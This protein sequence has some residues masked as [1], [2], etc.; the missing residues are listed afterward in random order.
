MD[1]FMEDIDEKEQLKGDRKLPTGEFIRRIAQY[2]RPELP[3][4]LGAALLLLLNVVFDIVL[5]L[6]TS[7]MTDNLWGWQAV[8]QGV[9]SPADWDTL[10]DI[11]VKDRYK[12]NMKAFFDRTSPWA[13]QS[14]TGRMLESVRKGFWQPPEA[15]RRELAATYARS[16]IVHGMACCDHTC[17]N[18]LLN[19]MVVSLISLPGVLSPEMV[20]KF[21]AA[22][23]KTGGKTLDR[24]V[25]ERRELQKSLAPAPGT[26][27]AL[28][29]SVQDSPRKEQR[30]AAPEKAA[31]KPVKGFRMKEKK[32]QPEETSISSSGLKW[33]I[34]AGVVLVI[35]IFALGGLRKEG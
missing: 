26:P 17:N 30:E 19:Q 4:F 11:F 27:A 22:V 34:L 14:I 10:N 28:K 8:T 1:E 32:D 5:P 33:T 12:L 23:E 31:A 18:P 24:Q 3:R 25:R 21:R 20:M 6:L 16:V 2:L 9:V 13:H 35:V 7:R 29:S 15:V